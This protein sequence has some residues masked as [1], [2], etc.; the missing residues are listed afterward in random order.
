MNGRGWDRAGDYVGDGPE[1]WV[2]PLLTF[3]IFGIGWILN[4]IND[5]KYKDGDDE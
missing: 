4:V 3:A 1:W 5:R 2:Y